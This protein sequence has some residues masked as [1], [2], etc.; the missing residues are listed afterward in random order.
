MRSSN[1]MSL[2]MMAN[3]QI[4]ALSR[5]EMSVTAGAWYRLRL[6]AV[7][8]R[9]HGYVNDVLHVEAT[10]DSHPRGN[11]GIVTYRTAARYDYLRVFQP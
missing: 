8:D 6:E 1:V 11:S 10:D 2:R 4:V 5:T 7:G 3:A 9:L